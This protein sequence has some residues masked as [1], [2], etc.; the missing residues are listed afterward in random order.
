VRLRQEIQRLRSQRDSYL[1][2]MRVVAESHVKFIE[3]AHEDFQVDDTD[4]PRELASAAPAAPP[5]P[6]PPVEEKPKAS[7][8]FE[9]LAAANPAPGE[10]ATE[11]LPGISDI[12]DRLSQS[13]RDTLASGQRDIP[14]QRETITPPRRDEAA[15]ATESS[16]EWN[17]EQFR[18]DL[19]NIVGN[20]H[21]GQGGR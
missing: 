16:S 6:R 9:A 15:P 18:R 4:L 3:S 17:M 11:A 19:Q 21:E 14:A 8:L 7:N 10:P 12:L 1:A 13:Q 20:P 5:A 2:K